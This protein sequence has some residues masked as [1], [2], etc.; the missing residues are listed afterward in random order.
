MFSI[1]SASRRNTLAALAVGMAFSGAA[2]AST[3]HEADMPGGMYSNKFAAPT[4]IANGVT[5]VRGTGNANQFDFLGFTNLPTAATNVTLA[6]SAPTGIDWSYSAGGQVLYSFDAFKWGWAGT[7]LTS[8]QLGKTNPTQFLNLSMAANTTG[9]LFLGFYFTHGRG[10]D[11][12]LNI[13]ANAIPG[14]QPQ[15]VLPSQPVVSISAVPLP[16]SLPLLGAAL[17]GVGIFGA[18]RKRRA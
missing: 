11:Y 1:F 3:V 8:F 16:A 17:F 12:G 15:I 9:K 7:T 4:V 6:I 10:M 2:T 18:R 14:A 13:N 5:T